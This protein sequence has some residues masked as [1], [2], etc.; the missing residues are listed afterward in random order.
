MEIS[1]KAGQP[2]RLAASRV[3]W[4]TVKIKR[5]QR[6]YGTKALPDELTLRAVRVE[7]VDP[8]PNVKSIVWLLLTTHEVETLADALQILEWY[9]ARWTVD[10]DQAWRL[11]RFCGWG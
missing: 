3:A 2:A 11:S 8:P 1:A 7:E 9:R 6:V 5:P 10:I 4:A